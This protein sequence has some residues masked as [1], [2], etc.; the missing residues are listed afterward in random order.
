LALI[1]QRLRAA[2]VRRRAYVGAALAGCD[3][4]SGCKW[5]PNTAACDDGDACTAGDACA[6]GKCATGKPIDVKT[7][8]ND[9][10]AC[11]DE[12]C[13]AKTGCTHS[14][15]TAACDDG[16]VC[17]KNEACAAGKCVG[18]KLADCDDGKPCTND[19]C[20][21]VTGNCSWT[22]KTGACEDGNGCTQ[23]DVCQAATCVPG[24]PITCDDG[25]SCTTDA[26]DGKTGAC[27]FTVKA[28]GG[29]P[30]CDGA[31][32]GGRCMKAFQ[33]ASTRAAAEQACVVWGGHL[34]RV[35]SAQENASVRLLATQ[36]CGGAVPAWI[37]LNDLA[38]EG[39]YE[40]PDGGAFGYSNWNPG[41]PNNC[42]ACCGA[43]EDV[44]QMI[45]NGHWNDICSNQV[46]T[47]YVCQRPLPALACDDASVCS[48][49]DTC[50][51]GKCTGALL[52][53]GDLHPCTV[54]SCDAKVGCLHAKAADGAACGAGFACTAGT[55]S[56]VRIGH[57]ARHLPADLAENLTLSHHRV[58]LAVPDGQHKQHLA[59][60][61]VQHGW[62]VE[63][64]QAV[65]L[66]EKPA[67]PHPL[68]RPPKPVP[69]KWLG[70]VQKA[71]GQASDAQWT[72]EVE[73]LAPA[74]R[75]QL[76]A[77]LLALQ[78]QI[79]ARLAAVP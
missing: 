23:G 41:E 47:C 24:V 20:D 78:G 29:V 58:L 22:G 50:V 37:G 76:R 16:S 1:P 25:N 72:A 49:A 68:G 36:G 67:L 63:Q 57:Q 44:V 6:N 10:N 54:D 40:W 19:L 53:G 79:L 17:T 38:V 35:G 69:L 64:L 65:I 60:M 51:A 70:A 39:K 56:L 42:D 33:A 15:N 31:V 30:A 73:R 4:V 14:N 77:E 8:C 18:G 28:G 52:N 66:G 34:T 43:P 45:D 48:S 11:T 5:T 75:A 46:M 13:A 7:V 32:V 55:C 3:A 9:A 12:G 61:A 62:T 27:S 21:A 59:R 74:H 26:C 71:V 2:R